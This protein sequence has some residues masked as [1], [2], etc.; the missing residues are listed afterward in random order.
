MSTIDA[1]PGKPKRMLNP[2]LLPI[3]AL[4]LV[5]LALLF[6]A[7]PLLL[8]SGNLQGNGNI[9]IQGNGLSGPQT[10]APGGGTVQKFSAGGNGSQGPRVT[11]GSGMLNGS[12][13][14]IFYFVLVL[15][16]LAAA[17]G[18][19][20]TKRWGQVL[21]IIMAVLYGISG[22]VSLLAT[23]LINLPG[24]GNPLSLILHLDLILHF[25]HVLLAAAVIVLAAIP[26][27]KLPTPTVPATTLVT[28]A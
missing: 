21:G 25:V 28:H 22:L 19:Y 7:T 27:Q 16:S 14:A 18:M 13:G 15:V 24:I 9:V 5:V 4:A 10:L 3:A 20:L 8:V 2:K 11:S 17:V 12:A 26:A 23:L 6:M 1:K